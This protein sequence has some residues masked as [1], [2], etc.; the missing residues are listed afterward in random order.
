MLYAYVDLSE[1]RMVEYH[2]REGSSKEDECS[3]KRSKN[4]TSIYP[5][6]SRRNT[7][8]EY[9]ATYFVKLVTRKKH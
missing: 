5:S 9:E 4:S 1:I 6:G 8:V 3:S 7:R 2:I